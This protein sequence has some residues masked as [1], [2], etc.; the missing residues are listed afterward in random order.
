MAVIDQTQR[1]A[2][3]AVGFSY[4][5]AMVLALFAGF[6]V[7]S[8]IIAPGDAARTAANIIAHERLFRLG[9]ASDLAAFGVDV[10]L[11]TALYLVLK[12]VNHGLA[13]LAA[14]FRVIETAI[15]VV[16]TLNYFDVLR[17]LT[18][19][20]Y[21]RPFGLEQLQA[22]AR[23]SLAAHSSG[24]NVGLMFAGIG[25]TIF[26]CLWYKSGYVPRALAAWGIFASFVLA[27]CCFAFI[28]FP[29]VAKTLTIAVF[30]GPIFIFELTMGFWLLFKPLR[31]IK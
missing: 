20:D 21:W 19:G 31:Q 17:F 12:P 23:A 3:R 30:G 26:C 16:I 7:L 2:A 24:Y 10:V 8:Q 15:M 29:E 4:L 18:A 28:I 5:I 22:F 27:V 1:T 14:L 6:Y 11:I 25:S 9:I 13:L